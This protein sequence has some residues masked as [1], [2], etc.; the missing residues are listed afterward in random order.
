MSETVK[1]VSYDWRISAKKAGFAFAKT[2]AGV[3]VASVLQYL[4][5]PENAK[6]LF[7]DYPALVAV[8][9]LVAGLCAYVLNALKHRE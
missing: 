2:L 3:A 7:G 4:A 5:S 1:L 9:P 6:A 8:A